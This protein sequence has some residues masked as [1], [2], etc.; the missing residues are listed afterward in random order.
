MFLSKFASGSSPLL[1][2]PHSPERLYSEL[3]RSLMD[4]RK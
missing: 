2:S 1:S 4:E 3:K